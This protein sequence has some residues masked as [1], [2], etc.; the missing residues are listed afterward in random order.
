MRRLIEYLFL[1]VLFVASPTLAQ[2]RQPD[3]ETSSDLHH[4]RRQ[5]YY[6][7][8]GQYD[9]SLYFRGALEAIDELGVGAFL[10]QPGRY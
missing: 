5:R 8:P 3:D 6:T 4:R 10:A 7:G 1:I 2:G 9:T